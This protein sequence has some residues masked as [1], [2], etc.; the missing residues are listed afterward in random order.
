MNFKR[1]LMQGA[2][3]TT[4]LS[5]VFS[6]FLASAQNQQTRSMVYTARVIFHGYNL[7]GKNLKNNFL[8]VGMEL[9]V[10]YPY[11]KGRTLFQSL[12]IGALRHKQHGNIYYVSTQFAY[13]PLLFKFLEPGIS[14]GIGRTFSF[15]NKQNPYY[16]SRGG[17]WQ[18]SNSQRMDH[19]HI[20]VGISIGYKVPARHYIVTPFLGYEGAVLLTYNSAF[21][22]LPYTSMSAGIRITHP[23]NL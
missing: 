8:N 3:K 22:V 14:L 4:L 6:S 10:D 7:P 23:K 16:S 1:L 21:P 20:P 17:E 11:N 5:C 13:R 18:K 15:A 2:A 9:G 19:W 12:N